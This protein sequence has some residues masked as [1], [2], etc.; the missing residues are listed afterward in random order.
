M[1]R[2]CIYVR[3]MHKAGISAMRRKVLKESSNCDGRTVSRE[4][5]GT[6][7]RKR[8]V[9][10]EEI[11]D[12]ERREKAL[13]SPNGEKRGDGESE[14]RKNDSEATK[15]GDEREEKEGEEE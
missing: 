6:D 14:T 8:D 9:V 11:K 4:N 15:R 7:S 1:L 12:R 13:S 2:V 3:D 5:Q 10:A